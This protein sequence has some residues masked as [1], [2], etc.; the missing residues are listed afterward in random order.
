M[1]PLLT[2]REN[3]MHSANMRLP[4]SFS[5]LEKERLVTSVIN[6]LDLTKKEHTI[7]GDLGGRSS[8]SGGQRKRV[9]IAIE[10]VMCPSI[11]YLD[12]PTSGLDSKTALALVSVLKDVA[13]LGI[14]VV[15]VI[16]QPRYEILKKCD[17]II[18]LSE[19]TI[20]YM[21]PSNLTDLASVFPRIKLKPREEEEHPLEGANAADMIVDYIEEFTWTPSKSKEPMQVRVILIVINSI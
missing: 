21:G 14:N 15:A 1:N 5:L 3:I 20:K 10:L 19:G 2:V 9:S 16:H 6:V 4:T 7:V 11:L 12:E 17:K 8:L 18:V 13:S